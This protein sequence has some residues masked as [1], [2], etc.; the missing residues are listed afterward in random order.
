MNTGKLDIS[1]YERDLLAECLVCDWRLNGA[2]RECA[3]M[4]VKTNGHAV[5][6]ITEHIT[7]YGPAAQPHPSNPAGQ[8]HDGQ[9]TR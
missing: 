6:F 1:K 4:H 5:Q 7:R 3:R 9:E 2:T 8:G